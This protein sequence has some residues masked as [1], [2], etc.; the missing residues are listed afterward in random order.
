MWRGAVGVCIPKLNANLSPKTTLEIGRESHLLSSVF[1]SLRCTPTTARETSG[2]EARWAGLR[3]WEEGKGSKDRKD[4]G[5]NGR[6]PGRVRKY[7]PE[8]RIIY[9]GFNDTLTV[10]SETNSY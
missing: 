5:G 10:V 7:N 8:G 3:W 9:A 2:L 6:A 1:P 4:G